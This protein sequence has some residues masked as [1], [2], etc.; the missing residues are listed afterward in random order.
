MAWPR[1]IAQ[2]GKGSG[3]MESEKNVLSEV[4][5]EKI[6]AK[7]QEDK[8]LHDRR[9]FMQEAVLTMIANMDYLPSNYRTPEML[10]RRA[11]ELWVAIEDVLV[12]EQEL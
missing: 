1:K 6:L 4:D 10:A 3:K 12:H 7:F 2:F 5:F 8:R 9:I 11:S